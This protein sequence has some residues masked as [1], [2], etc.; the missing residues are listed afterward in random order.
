MKIRVAQVSVKTGT[1]Q[2]GKWVNT[3]ITTEDGSVFSGFDEKLADLTEGALIEAEVV[4]KKGHNNIEEWKLLEEGTGKPGQ[5]ASEEP[6]EKRAS[7]KAAEL[8]VMAYVGLDKPVPAKVAEAF[9]LAMDWCMESLKGAN[10]AVK[11]GLNPPML[12]EFANRGEFLTAC[13]HYFGLDSQAV[14]VELNI[15]GIEELT[16][17]AWAWLQ[18]SGTRK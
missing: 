17:F 1:N 10:P 16:D 7:H 12:P 14:C 11:K 18:I 9:E 5:S 13:Y 6:L 4:V 15:G 2:Q 3:R 8:A